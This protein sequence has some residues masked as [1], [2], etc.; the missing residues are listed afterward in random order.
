[1][2]DHSIGAIEFLRSV[3]PESLELAFVP[4]TYLG[5]PWILLFGLLFAYWFL[6]RRDGGSMLG[7]A[8]AGAG[9]ILCLKVLV[10]LERP[11]VGPPV[12]AELAP[13]FL[14]P[15]YADVFQP[16]GEAFPSGHAM[17]ATVAWG[18]AAWLIDV[19][20]RRT[21]VAVAGVAVALVA[22]SRVVLGVHFAADV[23]GGVLIGAAFLVGAVLAVDRLGVD[24][25]TAFFGLATVL[26]FAG[27][28]LTGG[29][30]DAQLVAGAGVAG[31]AVRYGLD[32]PDRAWGRSLRG[33][34]AAPV[35]IALLLGPVLVARSLGV[36]GGI[37]AGMALGVGAAVALPVAVDRA[38]ATL[39]STPDVA[40]ER[41][42]G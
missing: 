21:R 32:V 16:G 3:L 15:L 6:D 20:Q 40:A 13:A 12:P 31:L 25:W 35:G 23:V 27:V 33:F 2:G 39:G 30:T 37:F 9:A 36:P 5:D 4:I 19:G 29:G 18:G 38:A 1:M 22:V 8:A 28:A 10:A 26:G 42:S 41:G 17:G 14:R 7:L 11:A 24:R 34:A